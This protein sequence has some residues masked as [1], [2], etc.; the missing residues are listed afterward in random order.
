MVMAAMDY[1]KKKFFTTGQIAK[2]C[3]VSIA[4]VQKWIDA[5][6]IESYRLPLT[7]SERRVPRESLLTFMRRY[8]VPTDELE[9][10]AP[11]YRVLVAQEDPGLRNQIERILG[12]LNKP[13]QVVTV[14]GG[15]EALIRM[16]ELKP[17]L[18]VFD[19][20]LPGIDGLRAMEFL[21]ES[22]EWKGTKIVV[23]SDLSGEERARLEELKAGTIIA[24]PV[25][26]Q[27]LKKSLLKLVD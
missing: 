6:E 11:S 13:A 15:V 4:T 3:G 18:L 7:A 8:N 5:G 27:Q 22:A 16:G 20:H 9:P 17:D 21:K 2:T 19:L 26:P 12:D 10:K 14:G 25:T 23:L 1:S 24:K